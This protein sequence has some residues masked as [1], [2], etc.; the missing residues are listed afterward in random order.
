MNII[1][2]TLLNKRGVF[3]I[4]VLLSTIVTVPGCQDHPPADVIFY[5][6]SIYTLDSSFS[7][8]EAMAVKDGRIVAT[9]TSDSIRRLFRAP[10]NVDLEKKIV[11]PGFN[12]AHSHFHGYAMG[13]QQVNLLGTNSYQD[14]V[15]RAKA[16]AKLHN[17]EFIEGRGWDHNDWEVKVFPDKA[18]LDSAF[19]STP[20]LLKRIDGHSA[21]ANQAALEYAGITDTTSVEGGKLLKENGRLT[22]VLIDNAVDLIQ[23][24]EASEEEQHQAIL[25]AQDSLWKYGITSL[26]DAGVDLRQIQLFEAMQDSGLLKIRINAMVADKPGLVDHFLEAGK[27]RKERLTLHSFKLIYMDGALGSRGA[28]MLEPYSDD[29]ENYGLMLAE[30]EHF[31][32]VA[33]RLRDAGWQSALHAIGDSA[34]RSALNLYEQVLGDTSWDHRWRI[35]HAQ[36]VHPDDITRFGQLGVIPSVQ[37]THATSDMYWA[38]DRLGD[39]R[40]GEAYPYKSL[41][42]SAGVL[43]LGTDFPVESIDPRK[44]FVAAVFR[45]DAEAHPKDGFTPGQKLSRENTLRGMT[46]WPA[47]ASFEEDR[48][49]SLEPGKFADFIVLEKDIMKLDLKEI[50]KT[51]VLRTYIDGQLVYEK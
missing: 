31:V 33:T 12:D 5:N 38:K 23:F 3:K 25:W 19:P 24:P 28:L 30:W 9:G 46:I 8:A 15:R 14:V 42:Q 36:I 49:G 7:I 41:L 50:L 43:P 16:F 40:M 1:C 18:A 22:G 35:E 48:K 32:E 27:I 2:K 45:Q 47:Y 26:S 39:E 21:I 10:K 6:A 11:Y 20:V 51:Q 4:L 29:P 17:P 37:P 44:T 13:L 34:N